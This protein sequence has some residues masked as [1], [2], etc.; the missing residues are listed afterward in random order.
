MPSYRITGHVCIS[1][2]HE[3]EAS[4]A[5]EAESKVEEMRLASFDNYSTSEGENTIYDV[6]PLDEDGNEIEEEEQG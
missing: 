5:E 1:F 6:I 2:V 3:L 4:S